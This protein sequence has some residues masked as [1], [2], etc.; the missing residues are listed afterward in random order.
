MVTIKISL[1]EQEDNWLKSRIATGAYRNES[2]VISQLIQEQIVLENETP[3]EIA[4]I[5]EALIEAEE[6]IKL[7]GYSTQTVKEIWEEAKSEYLA[8]Q[9][10]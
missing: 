5:R 8:K 3:E 2:E 10:E 7:D 1:T 9:S 4:A 6:S